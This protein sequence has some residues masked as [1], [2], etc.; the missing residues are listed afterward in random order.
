MARERAKER[1]EKAREKAE[2][3]REKAERKAKAQENN[4]SIT[5]RSAIKKIAALGL[6]AVG[7]AIGT[8]IYVSS[9]GQNAQPENSPRAE[10]SKL[11]YSDFWKNHL[12]NAKGKLFAHP[13]I[14]PKIDPSP[15]TVRELNKTRKR[16]IENNSDKNPVLGTDLRVYKEFFELSAP[17]DVFL[18][19]SRRAKTTLKEFYD[20]IGRPDLMAD[21]S[22]RRLNRSTKLEEIGSEIISK[23]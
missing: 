14:N 1:A 17:D 15:E 11:S 21:I 5:R 8:G 3:A 10:L 23:Y 18:E 9:L 16:F 19:Y 4:K 22:F 13:E 6:L 2:R 7:S 12:K 20:Y